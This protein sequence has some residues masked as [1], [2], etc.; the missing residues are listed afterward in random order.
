[1][2]FKDFNEFSSSEHPDEGTFEIDLKSISSVALA[3]IVEEVKNDDVSVTRSYDRT[4]N[5]HNR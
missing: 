2:A 5:R 3:R 4:H 1:M